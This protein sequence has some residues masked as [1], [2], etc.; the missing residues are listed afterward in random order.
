MSKLAFAV[1][2]V[3]MNDM[4]SLSLSLDFINLFV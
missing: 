2:F 1:L 4:L 3:V